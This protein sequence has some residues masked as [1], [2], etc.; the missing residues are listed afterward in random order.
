MSGPVKVICDYR[1]QLPGIRDQGSRPQCLTFA[2]SDANSYS[3]GTQDC[4]SVEYL[5][6]HAANNQTCGGSGF[7]FESIALALHNQGQPLEHKFP[8]DPTCKQL[9]RPLK[10][11]KS[12]YTPL[13]KAIL[14]VKLPKFDEIIQGLSQ[15]KLFVLGLE[16]TQ[17]FL[18]NDPSAIFSDEVGTRGMHAV[19]AVGYGELPSGELVILVRNSWGDLW[20]DAGHGWITKCLYSNKAANAAELEA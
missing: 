15:G 3:N 18:R 1:A 20:G 19:L 6:L 16:V 8:Y 13:Y 9:T 7:T 14:L 4:L 10:Y 17:G 5:A 12:H 11:D 2:A